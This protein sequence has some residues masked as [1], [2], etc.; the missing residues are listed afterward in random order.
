MRAEGQIFIILQGNVLEN[1]HLALGLL[2][3]NWREQKK[4]S[5]YMIGIGLYIMFYVI[6][7]LMVQRL[8]CPQCGMFSQD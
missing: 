1:T 2:Y 4:E 6:A 5:K 8:H 7:G 3:M